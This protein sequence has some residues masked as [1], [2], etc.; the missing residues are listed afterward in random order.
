MSL[1]HHIAKRSLCC[2]GNLHI[3]AKFRLGRLHCCG[4][5]KKLIFSIWR[6]SAILVHCTHPRDHPRCVLGGIYHCTKFGSNRFS[7]FD[8]VEVYNDLYDLSGNCLF[9]PL[10]ELFL[11]IWSLNGSIING[12]PQNTSLLG[13]T[14]F[15]V[16]SV[17]VGATVSVLACRKNPQTKK[18]RKTEAE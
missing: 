4:V 12:T 7:N 16:L 13:T 2:N 1:L 14:P 17:K 9:T 18:K 15:D 3:P 6:P 11:G 8:N 10:L 5:I